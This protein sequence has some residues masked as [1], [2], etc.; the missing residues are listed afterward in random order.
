MW[1]DVARNMS[2]LG[3]KKI[4]MLVGDSDTG[5][6]TLAVYLTN[7]VLRQGLVPC[8][9]D[10]DIGQGDL[11]PPAGI[12]AAVIS[13]PVTDLRDAGATLYEF[14]GST[15]PAGFEHIVAKRMRSI[16]ERARLLG[17]I[18]IVNTDGYARNGGTQYK[19]MLAN[20]IGPDMIVCLENLALSGALKRGPWKVVSAQAS[21][22]VSKTRRERTSRRLDQF[23]RH[24]GEGLATADLSQIKFVYMD[25]LF[26]A[27]ELEHPP[28]VQLEPENMTRMFVGLGSNGVVV[29]FGIIVGIEAGRIAIQTDVVNFDRVYLSNIRLAG[30]RPVEIR[31]A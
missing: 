10:G 23:L 1:H 22:Q 8:V 16:L 7:V 6:S 27:S 26:S 25:R 24:V 4:L 13:K 31:I 28:I 14:V 5:K 20:A 18:C 15:S 29:G 2:G 3:S 21:S 12:G 11:A 19:L 17:D 30:D 9:I